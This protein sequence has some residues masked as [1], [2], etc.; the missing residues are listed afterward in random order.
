MLKLLHAGDFHLDTPFRSLPPRE[1]ARR[2][3]EQRR[4][5]DALRDLAVARGVDLAL[6]AGDL[7]DASTIYPETVEALSA[8]LAGFPCPVCI[9]PGNHDPFTDRSPYNT[10]IWPDN[11][12]IFRDPA[13]S[14]V[15]FPA[16]GVRVYGFAFTS[17]VWEDDPLAGFQAPRDGLVDLG[18][19]HTQV[20]KNNPYAPIDPVSLA[21]S[22]L[23][24]AA[25]GHVHQAA[26][27]GLSSPTPW[28][29][30][31]CLMGRGFDEPGDKGAAIVTLEDGRTV[32]W[33]LVPLAQSRYQLLEVDVTGRDP[34][35]ALLDALGHSH[36]EDYCRVT[37]RGEA[38]TLDLNLLQTA[39]QGR[40][41]ALELRSD[42]TLPLDTWARMEEE[43]LT[44]LFLRQMRQRIDEASDPDAR[45]TLQLALRY[46]LA[47]LEGRDAP[48]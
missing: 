18:V 34:S 1:A 41:R 29:Y 27:P 25:L 26:A 9:A 30:C 22:G 32:G 2:R 36:L 33:E 40:C 45:R 48:L 4:A 31:G 3:Q 19:F 23:A 28:A 17:P 16:L 43:T 20:G 11:V 14:A 37:L 12:H 6:L 8:A 21:K 46:G 5:L 47:A 42:T 24:Y 39:A 35:A 15:S 7:F 10:Q 44:G 38:A 13:V